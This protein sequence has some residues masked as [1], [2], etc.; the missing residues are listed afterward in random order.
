MLEE[1]HMHLIDEECGV[2]GVMR[3]K[4]ASN[5]A[6]LG[7]HALQHRGQEA[8]GIATRDGERI[9]VQRRRGLVSEAFDQNT[10]E[11][12]PGEVAIGHVRYSTAGSSSIRNA[13]PI[14][15]GTKFGTLTL[16]HNGNLTNALSLR[17]KFEE[18]GSIFATESDTEVIAHLVARSYASDMLEALLDALR[19]VKGAFSLVGLTRDFMFALRDPH[20]VRPL[21]IGHLNG[22]RVVASESSSFVLI[23]G[24]VERELDPGEMLVVDNDGNEQFIKP[25]L[26]ITPRPCVFELVYFSR[27][28]STVFGRHV[29]E[30]RK[31]MGE[32]IARESGVE[33]DVV[34]P[35]PDSGV[36]AAIGFANA[37]GLPFEMGLVR[38]HYVGRTFIEP[39]HSIRHFGV[40][41]KLS[42]VRSILEGKRVV[43]VD[44]SIVRGTTSRKIIKMIR[45]AG[46]AEVHFR[47]ASP[48]TV[49]PCF[50]GIDTPSRSELIASSHSL[51]EIR[52]Y[53]TADSLAYISVDGLREAVGAEV[54]DKESNACNFCEA[55]FTR[56]YPIELT[57]ARLNHEE[58]E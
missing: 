27:P 4:E 25:F 45:E 2:F 46:A 15:V 16:A 5:I 24:K 29:Y 43:V 23:G 40:K 55:C 11:E 35:V 31:K 28:D 7:L 53:I 37:S 10:L 8:C 58:Q 21:V 57:D 54:T 42:P 13:Q 9:L 12:L 20:G 33:A 32:I 18:S 49:S 1:E 52:D 34:I 30:T 36:P 48:P 56:D 17:K 19:Q 6:Y 41:L 44:D 14:K 38:S 22:A 51:D 26:P 50:Y 47:V 39:S 3:H